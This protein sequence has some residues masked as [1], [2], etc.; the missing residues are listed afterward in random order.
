MSATTTTSPGARQTFSWFMFGL[1]SSVTF[2][3]ILSELV[4]SGILPQMAASLA[5]D[6]GDVGFLVGVYA[7]ASAVFAIPLVS[8]TLAVNRKLLLQILLAGFA[9]SNI[10]VAFASSYY[11]IVA[12]RILGGIC[13]GVM[14]PMIAAYGTRLVPEHLHGRAITVI[15]AGNTLGISIGLPVMTT[16]GVTFGWR[17]AFVVLGL[18]VVAI[19]VL[20][21]FFL[22]S[23]DGERMSKTNSP[24][25]IIRMP[26]IL[27][28][29]LLTFLSVVAHY[30]IY[31]YI[32][33]LVARLDL[34]GGIGLA[35]LIFGIGSVISVVLS[36]RYIDAYL[37]PLIVT[38]LAAG[39]AAMALFLA[40]PSSTTVSIAGF[41]LWGLAFGPLVTMYQTAV[42]RQIDEAKDVATSVQSS[43]FN[44]SIMVG[45][46]IGGMLLDGLLGSSDVTGIVWLSLGCFVLATIVAFLSRRTLRPA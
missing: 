20:V 46:W 21:Q 4:P 44:L 34:P 25:A 11:L 31:T 1:M 7:L 36:A 14:W 35:L 26:T 5:I 8:A 24:L 19:G 39:G 32:T 9:I 43:V 18:I 37:R 27:I 10:V 17:S 29:L 3:G 15:M 41:L 40:F 45:T 22:P 23:V 30:G 2:V 6:E 16:I 13:A 33:L 42:S 12:S 38:A 28:V